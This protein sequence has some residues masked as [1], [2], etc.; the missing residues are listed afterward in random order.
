MK[1][2]IEKNRIKFEPFVATKN[3]QKRC[4]YRSPR[5]G[6]L[7]SPIGP[8]PTRVECGDVKRVYWFWGW[9]LNSNYAWRVMLEEIDGGFA[10]DL[11]DDKYLL[12]YKVTR[13]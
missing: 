7:L 10:L 8:A 1:Y 4:V 11:I 2:N 9:Y 6:I 5:S 13:K 3:L 12:K